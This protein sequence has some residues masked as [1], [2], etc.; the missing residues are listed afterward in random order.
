MVYKDMIVSG[1][2]EKLLAF[3]PTCTS[4]IMCYSMFHFQK[5]G[6]LKYPM[7]DAYFEF[8]RVNGSQLTS[9]NLLATAFIFFPILYWS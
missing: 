7:H 1:S 2:V 3:P 4:H 8:S 9:Q 6:A 5:K